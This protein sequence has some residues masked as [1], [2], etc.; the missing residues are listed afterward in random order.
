MARSMT[1]ADVAGAMA[2][3]DASPSVSGHCD[4]TAAIPASRAAVTMT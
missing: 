3:A 2:R 4:M 1:F